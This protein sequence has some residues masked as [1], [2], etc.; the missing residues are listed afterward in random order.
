MELLHVPVISKMDICRYDHRLP[1]RRIRLGLGLAPT[2]RGL[3]CTLTSTSTHLASS[4]LSSVSLYD[5]ILVQNIISV[6]YLGSR[7]QLAA[8]VSPRSVLI[9]IVIKDGHLQSAYLY[10]ALYLPLPS[11]NVK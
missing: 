7:A 11:R 5:S 4:Y 2:V 3:R 6:A 9:C 8:K 10:E 1:T